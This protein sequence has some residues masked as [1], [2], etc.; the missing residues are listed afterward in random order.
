M[1]FRFKKKLG[2]NF[3]T[4]ISITRKIAQVVDDKENSLVVEI[5][6]GDGRLTKQLCKLYS[7][8][9]GYEIDKEVIP[10]L[11]NNLKTVD[12]CIIICDDFMKRDL[13]KDLLTYQY[14]KLYI[15]GN[16][17][18]YITTPIIEKLINTNLDINEMVFMVQKEV[19]DRFVARPG[20][21]DYGSITV[22]LNYYYDLKKE[23]FVSKKNFEPMPNVDSV[24]I[25]F[26][27]KENPCKVKNEELFFKLVKDSFTHKRKTLK[28][29]LEG[30]NLEKVSEVLNKYDLDLSVRAENIPLEIFIE[31]ANNL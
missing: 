19:G 2:Q 25:S 23:F 26:K 20:S 22:F 8:V 7:R 29:N 3:L 31:I 30:Y 28:N 17:P 10:Y 9:L 15:F 5:G 4:Q 18:Y 16:L 11:Y 12:N 14:D 6:C 21:K 27:K 1:G 13:K 24:V